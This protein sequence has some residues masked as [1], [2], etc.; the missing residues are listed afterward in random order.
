[1]KNN[2]PILMCMIFLMAIMPLASAQTSLGTFEK[3]TSVSLIQTCDNSTY[4]NITRI[5]YPNSTFMI[6][7][8]TNMTRADDNY[9]YILGYN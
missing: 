6:N 9:N 1:M 7:S 3:N 5:L 4:S 8:Q 2:L